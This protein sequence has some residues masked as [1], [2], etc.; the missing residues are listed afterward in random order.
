MP[1]ALSPEAQAA[2]AAYR[3]PVQRVPIGA[4]SHP[5]YVWRPNGKANEG[6]RLL[7]REEGTGPDKLR[8]ATTAK[9]EAYHRRRRFAAAAARVEREA[10]KAERAA[11]RAAAP[12]RPEAIARR[13]R[14]RDV[15]ESYSK[16]DTLKTIAARW[17][18]SPKTISD[19]VRTLKLSRRGRLLVRSG[20]P[21]DVEARREEVLRHALAG[22]GAPSVAAAMG[23]NLKTVA[24]DMTALRKAGRL[25]AGSPASRKARE[26]RER[27]R[28]LTEAGRSVPEVAAELGLSKTTVTKHRLALKLGHVRARHGGQPKRR[29]AGRDERIA[30]RLRAGEWPSHVCR[31]EGC[32]WPTVQRVAREAGIPLP[33]RRE[34]A[35]ANAARSR[36]AALDRRAPRRQEVARLRAEGLSLNA[37][38]AALGVAPSTV[39]GDLR[40]DRQHHREAA[41]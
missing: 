25:D 10:A 15:A 18:C 8:R 37:I 39:W 12:E 22:L 21:L 4:S 28:A 2:I 17:G 24:R 30:A 36:D 5:G 14:L 23:L 1:D 40:P 11:A 38:A 34:A 41:E 32:G 29:D 6:G 3:G 35:R 27:V 7:T 9:A 20:A 26:T 31:S 33:S 19:D 13:A 16:G